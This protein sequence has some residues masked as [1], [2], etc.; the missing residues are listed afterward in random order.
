MN[1]PT[2]FKKLLL[3]GTLIGTAD[4]LAAFAHAWLRSSVSPDRVLRFVA[5]G[6]WGDA[7]FS[8]G[9][10]MLCWGLF[11]HFFIAFGWATLFLWAHPLLKKWIANPWLLGIAYGVFVWLVMNLAIL[12]M[13]H[14]PA[15]KMTAY[16]VVSG[17]TILVLAIGLPLAFLVE[18]KNGQH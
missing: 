8:G 17:T 4:I 3:A 10:S 18:S 1:Q 9:Q 5:S 2:F 11:F 7:A 12:P 15:L 13:S 6:F 16:S 14:V